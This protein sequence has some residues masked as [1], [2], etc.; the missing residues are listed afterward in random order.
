MIFLF[1]LFFK[2]FFRIL[3]L[4]LK[5][6][7]SVQIHVLS[8]IITPPVYSQLL[9]LS[10]PI[11]YPTPGIYVWEIYKITTLPWG[12]SVSIYDLL[13]SLSREN[14]ERCFSDFIG[15][16]LYH[17]QLT[18]L[19]FNQ[20]AQW[21]HI[22]NK[23]PRFLRLHL[24]NLEKREFNFYLLISHWP[25]VGILDLPFSVNGKK[26]NLLWSLFHVSLGWER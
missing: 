18:F 7:L 25:S 12:C 26:I 9:E 6:Y 11:L 23:E 22:K 14:T 15:V 4:S 3:D 19:N 24:R 21:G 1:C 10:T 16:F 2:F 8:P 17:H 5:V 20:S 13:F